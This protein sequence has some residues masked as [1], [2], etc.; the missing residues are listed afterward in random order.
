MT[1]EKG[2]MKRL[3]LLEELKLKC[4]RQVSFDRVLH[5][6]HSHN[7][8]SPLITGLPGLQAVFKLDS[9]TEHRCPELPT[10]TS[11]FLCVSS[12][13]PNFCPVVMQIP[14]LILSAVEGKLMGQKKIRL[15]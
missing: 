5:N 10:H 9:S 7:L 15:G 11:K 12:S 8:F 3:Q 2:L 1:C 4:Y 6:L 13:P 14:A